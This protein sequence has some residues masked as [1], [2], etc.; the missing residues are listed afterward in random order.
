M[1]KRTRT[2]HWGGGDNPLRSIRYYRFSYDDHSFWT[3]FTRRSHKVELDC[4]FEIRCKVFKGKDETRKEEQ[5]RHMVLANSREFYI[6]DRNVLDWFDDMAT[7]G[8]S[9]IEFEIDSSVAYVIGGRP[10]KKSVT[11][12]FSDPGLAT[13]FKLAFGGK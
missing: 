9:V 6:K 1:I 11:A 10:P 8:A 13:M 2:W 7:R 5:V 4:D 3:R 12:R